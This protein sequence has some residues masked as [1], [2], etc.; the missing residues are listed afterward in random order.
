MPTAS[1]SATAT[2]CRRLEGGERSSRYVT[3]RADVQLSGRFLPLSSLLRR[4]DGWAVADGGDTAGLE[5]AAVEAGTIVVVPAA[6]D[7]AAPDDDAAV[8]VVEG[9]L[10]GLLD[11]EGEVGV[12]AWRHCWLEVLDSVVLFETG[13]MI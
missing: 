10:A 7:L 4:R 8:P 1:S 13:V 2:D 3:G 5:R 11:A 6:E 9:R 12:G